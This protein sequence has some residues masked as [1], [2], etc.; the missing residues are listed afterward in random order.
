MLIRT[1]DGKIME[2]NQSD[3]TNLLFFYKTVLRHKYNYIPNE[4]SQIQ[5]LKKLL[6]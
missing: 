6:R 5:Y 1:L 3:Y 4:P 2:I